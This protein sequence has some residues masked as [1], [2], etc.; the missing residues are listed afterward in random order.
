MGFDREYFIVYKI[1]K[2]TTAAVTEDP[3]VPFHSIAKGKVVPVVN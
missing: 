1:I 2:Q 3:E